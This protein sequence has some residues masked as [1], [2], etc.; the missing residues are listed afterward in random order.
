M[1]FLFCSFKVNLLQK[2][3]KL[4]LP[5][6]C[7]ILLK[8]TNYKIEIIKPFSACDRHPPPVRRRRAPDVVLPRSAARRRLQRDLRLRGR[9]PRQHL[10]QEQTHLGRNEVSE[11]HVLEGPDHGL[12]VLAQRSSLRQVQ[13][14]PRKHAGILLV[15]MVNLGP[16]KPLTA[17]GGV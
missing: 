11:G 6:S 17:V 13:R 10:H 3:L 5:I 4:N 15:F 1:I 2:M 8:M 14:F 12:Q 7:S 16:G 9:Q